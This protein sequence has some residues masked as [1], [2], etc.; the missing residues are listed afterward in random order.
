VRA[1]SGSSAPAVG[2]DVNAGGAWS[3]KLTTITPRPDDCP[4]E[5]NDAY[6]RYRLD[7]MT[8]PFRMSSMSSTAV[9][10]R[11]EM[12]VVVSE[13]YGGG[14]ITSADHLERFF[15]AWGLGLVRWD[16]GRMGSCHSFLQSGRLGIGLR[17]PRAVLRSRAMVRLARAGFGSTVVPGLIWFGSDRD[18]GFRITAGP[19][20]PISIADP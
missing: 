1:C 16:A 8:L 5:F 9:S 2:N 12:E 10:I 3:E 4:T 19:C 14:S 15:F 13:H 6:T 20:S 18:G 11:H 7:R 17:T